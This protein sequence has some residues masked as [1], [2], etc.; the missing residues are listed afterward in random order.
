[1]W[2]IS[3]ALLPPEPPSTKLPSTN[4]PSTKLPS[5]KPPSTTLDPT[6]QP[7]PKSPHMPLLKP[8]LTGSV[9]QHKV[10]LSSCH[11]LRRE[12]NPNAEIRFMVR[13]LGSKNNQTYSRHRT[14]KLTEMKR[15]VVS[16]SIEPQQQSLSQ[17]QQRLL[18]QQQV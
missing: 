14:E 2:V 13:G 1:M 11:S 10:F 15:K 3:T 4:P 6:A 9:L 12:L 17:V 5:T 8:P 7:S 16:S 18:W